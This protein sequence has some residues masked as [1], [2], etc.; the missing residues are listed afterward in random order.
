MRLLAHLWGDLKPR[1]FLD[2]RRK[3]RWFI[4]YVQ[5]RR[6][7]HIK[8][9]FPCIEGDYVGFSICVIMVVGE[10]RFLSAHNAVLCRAYENNELCILCF[11]SSY[12]LI[13]GLTP[14]STVFQL[15][16]REFNE[17]SVSHSIN[18]SLEM[19]DRSP[20]WTLKHFIHSKQF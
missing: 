5:K 6:I 2:S 18:F 11:I 10:A 14:L 3:I 7:L 1:S 19:N 8:Y 20:R 16:R 17:T 13:L 9:R 15:K 4:L 12:F